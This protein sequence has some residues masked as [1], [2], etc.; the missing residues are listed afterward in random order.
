METSMT[1]V[2]SF[3][4]LGDDIDFGRPISN[5][6]SRKDT[7]HPTQETSFPAAVGN[8]DDAKNL[9]LDNPFS[10][11]FYGQVQP[12][13]GFHL[14]IPSEADSLAWLKD[15]VVDQHGLEDFSPWLQETIDQIASPEADS[16]TNV[17]AHNPAPAAASS[18]RRPRR[19]NHA[20]DQCRIAKRACN[21]RNDITIHRQKPPN[22]CTTCVSRGLECTVAWLETKKASFQSSKRRLPKTGEDLTLEPQHNSGESSATFA[23]DLLR[24]IPTS[25]VQLVRY[26]SAREACVH[27]FNLYVDIVD[28]PLSH[29]LLPGMMPRRYSLG[30]GALQLLSK[31][32]SF[33]RFSHRAD[34]WV[35]TCWNAVPEARA[36]LAV[37]PHIYH[38]VSILDAIFEGREA[39]PVQYRPSARD[40][41]INKAFQWAALAAASQFALNSGHEKNH[42][43]DFAYATWQKAKEAIFDNA[44]ATGSFRLAKA[45]LLFGFIEPPAPSEQTPEPREASTYALCEGARRLY[46]LCRQARLCLKGHRESK[47][48]RCFW[49]KT[50]EDAKASSAHDLPCEVQDH[51]LELIGAVEWLYG[52]AHAAKT[53]MSRGRVQ[54][55]SN[56]LDQSSAG[57]W[58]KRHETTRMLTMELP[59]TQQEIDGRGSPLPD[60]PE[61]R[62]NH[63]AITRLWHEKAQESTMLEK[64][65]QCGILAILQWSALAR[66]TT[67]CESISSGEYYLEEAQQL[68]ANINS[69]VKL[70]RANFGI[71]DEISAMY[72]PKVPPEIRRMAALISNDC[73]LGVLLYFDM[74]KGLRSQLPQQPLSEARQMLDQELQYTLEFC[75]KQRLISAT[76]ISSF[77][78]SRLV[79]ASPGIR[80][81]NGLKA[82]VGD[83]GAHPVSYHATFSAMT[84]CFAC[85]ED[86]DANLDIRTFSTPLWLL[87]LT[88]WRRLPCQ[89]SF[90]FWSDAPRL[91]R[92]PRL[93]QT[94]TGA[95]KLFKPSRSHW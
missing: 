11:P 34:Q 94:L 88:N 83:L 30:V 8:I 18:L 39:K 33:R 14:P 73:D 21:F 53:V 6:G 72:F 45:F 60:S 9:D 41:A 29:F 20:C 74:V 51:L 22:P 78:R 47:S 57:F 40:E 58:P 5:T 2:V 24:T 43:R 27:H 32:D 23:Q 70:Y 44:G 38:T 36:S 19:Q 64:M 17:M 1:D 13:H 28:M 4:L 16:G 71:Y 37:A 80:G 93:R 35:N 67:A 52:F 66:L 95:S 25:D 42:C 10:L 69:I 65:K 59:E 90:M 12:I 3:D 87:G 89:K 62:I 26:F 84:Y 92:P 56:E 49:A 76:Q 50:N 81:A 48:R 82:Q 68:C 61:K 91:N 79:G 46:V 54:P 85:T 77:A 55:L 31:K 15:S 63:V 75:A 86:S 7:Y